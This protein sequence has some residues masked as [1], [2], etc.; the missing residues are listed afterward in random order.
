VV[1][2]CMYCLVG[3]GDREP[4]DNPAVTHGACGPCVARALREWATLTGSPV[5]DWVAD[6]MGETGHPSE[7]IGAEAGG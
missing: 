4:F 7:L 3:L 6:I 1:A 5:P 2:K